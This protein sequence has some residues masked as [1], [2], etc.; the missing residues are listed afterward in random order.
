MRKVIQLDEHFASGEPTLQTGLLWTP[1]GRPSYE[2]T[3]QASDA[4]DYI[5][6]VTPKPGMTIVLVLALGSY[7]HW[8]LNRNGDGFNEFPYKP[9]IKPLCGCCEFAPGGWISQEDVLP[10]HYKS[11]EQYGKNYMHHVNK[12]PNKS[13]GDVLKAFWNPSMHRVELLVG[14]DNTKAPEIVQR[15]ADGEYPAVSMGCRIKYDVC[16]ICGHRAPTRK[17]YCPHLKNGLRQVASNGLRAG[18]LNPSPRFF[19]ISWVIKPAD[20]TGFLMKKVAHTYELRSSAEMG[21]YLDRVEEKRAAIRKVADIDK[22]VRGLPVD[23]K[24]SPIPPSEV[25]NIQRYRDQ[26]MPMHVG[27]MPEMD[28]HTIK[29]LADYPVNQ[30]LSTMTAAGV[31][32]TTPE[33]IKMVVEKLAPGTQVP[34]GILDSIV[35]LQGQMFEYFTANPQLLDQLMQTRMFDIRAD[36]VRPEI[37]QVAEK[38]LEKRSSIM[39]YLGRALM[40]EPK[41]DEGTP[42]SDVFHVRDPHTGREYQT[43]RGA[44]WAAHDAIAK[45][46]LAKIVGGAAGLT[47]AYKIVA[48]GLPNALKPLAA[49]TAAMI[50]YKNLQPDFGPQYQTEEGVPISTMTELSPKQANNLS[51]IALPVLGVSALVTA[52]GHD[53]DTRLRYGQYQNPNAP[54]HEKIMNQAGEFSSKHP[55]F[56]TLAG[57]T[58]YGLGRNA[59]KLSTFLGDLAEKTADDITLPSIDFD[60]FSEKFGSLFTA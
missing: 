44:A 29:R 9:G 47:A 13:V 25:M 40:P 35:S 46:Q 7:C 34:D 39:N 10:A 59:L 23:Q 16:N 8:D 26:V 53:Y 57:L 1:S 49:G 31:I 24:T 33:F 21:E 60:L 27:A 4:S 43:T 17:Q 45:K 30:V 2:L 19:D 42:K 48:S 14:I 55:G 36:N 56:S 54:I 15:I 5:K 28:N 20:E 32:L 38:Y 37:G 6:M 51:S 22:I 41:R 18:A 50:G 11:F 52:L 58:A 12:D 3:K